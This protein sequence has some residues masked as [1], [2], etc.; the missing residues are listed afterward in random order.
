M[1]GVAPSPYTWRM[2]SNDVAAPLAAVPRFFDL[3]GEGDPRIVIHRHVDRV[4]RIPMPAA[5]IDVNTPE[6]LLEIDARGPG[7]AKL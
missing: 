1:E 4:V 2:G 6:D 3:R 7:R 5:A